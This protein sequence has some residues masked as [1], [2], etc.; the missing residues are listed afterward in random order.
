MSLARDFD[1]SCQ[2]KRVFILPIRL[3]DSFD[4]LTQPG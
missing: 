3:P 1:A 2:R 4:I